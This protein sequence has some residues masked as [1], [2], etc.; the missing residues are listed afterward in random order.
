MSRTGDRDRAGS[1][2]ALALDCGP[3]Q[4]AKSK[5]VVLGEVLCM[6]SVSKLLLRFDFSLCK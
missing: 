4:T 3:E 5:A 1:A 2:G 6:L